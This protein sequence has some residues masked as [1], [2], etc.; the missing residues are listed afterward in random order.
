MKSSVLAHAGAH[1][2]GL[3]PRH[4]FPSAA[5]RLRY[6]SVASIDKANMVIAENPYNV[7]SYRA[8]NKKLRVILPGELHH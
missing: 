1:Q 2:V 5:E 6:E 7:A 8:D 3:P 4:I